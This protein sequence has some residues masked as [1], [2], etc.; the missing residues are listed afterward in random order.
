MMR[1][2]FSDQTGNTLIQ[3]VRVERTGNETYIDRMWLVIISELSSLGY[4]YTH[5]MYV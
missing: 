5:R 1:L 3:D 4:H 2:F